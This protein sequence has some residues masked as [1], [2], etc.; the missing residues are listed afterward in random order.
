VRVDFVDF[1]LR[2]SNQG[3]CSPD[4]RFI[5]LTILVIAYSE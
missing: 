2:P 5:I 4:N 3:S 1:H